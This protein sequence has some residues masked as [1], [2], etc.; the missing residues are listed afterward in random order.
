MS[1]AV[2]SSGQA[3]VLGHVAEEAPHADRVLAPRRC[4]TPR[5]SPSVGW[6]TPEH[7]P[8]EGGLA[9]AVRSDQPD[10]PGR[11][12]HVEPVDRRDGR[13]ALGEAPGPEQHGGAGHG[14]SLPGDV[15]LPGRA[16]Y[17]GPLRQGSQSDLL[18]MQIGRKQWQLG[19]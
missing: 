16:L 4:R 19:P 8:E 15:V 3:V 9:G 7:H 14:G 1:A 5:A 17:P 11:H 6:L 10:P 12:L 18:A 13:V 2:W